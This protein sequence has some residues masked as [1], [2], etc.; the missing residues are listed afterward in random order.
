MLKVKVK[1][2]KIN[3]SLKSLIGSIYNVKMES[4]RK[5]SNFNFQWTKTLNQNILSHIEFFF[6]LI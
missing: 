2:T 3:K 4:I 1:I 6:T 5:M